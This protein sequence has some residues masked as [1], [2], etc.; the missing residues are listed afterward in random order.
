MLQ[1]KDTKQT[2]VS[3]LGE[4]GLIKHLTK[5]FSTK[6]DSTIFG[7]GDDAAVIDSG[8]MCHLLSTDML[9]EGVHFDLSYVPLKHLGY[10]AVS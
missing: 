3:E 4:F 6:N 2:P 5:E 10:K 8:K 1:N 7:V 9:I